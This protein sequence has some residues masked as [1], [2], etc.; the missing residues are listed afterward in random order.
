MQARVLKMGDIFLRITMKPYTY[1]LYHRPTKTHYYGVRTAKNCNPTELWESYFSTSKSV[2]RLIEE[3]GKDSFDCKVRKI[4]NDPLDALRWEHKFLSKIDAASR[5]DWLNKYNGG[6]T[7]TTAQQIPWNKGITHSESTKKILS[8][9]RK[10]Y[11][12]K[13]HPMFG[14]RH[15]EESKEKMSKN[16]KRRFGEK[17]HFYGKRHTDDV[18]KIISKKNTGR[19]S[20]N[21]G[22]PIS[23]ERKLRQSETMKNKP[24]ITC[25]F[26]KKIGHPSGM[27]RY[28]FDRCKFK[29]ST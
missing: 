19:P 8:E 16:Q 2:K 6:N 29:K 3:Y 28:H 10:R 26:C 5:L 18:K 13:R 4:F 23:D 25:P 17:N 1:Y 14:K 24:R 27:K 15:T 12:G 11:T 7:F 22:I 20:P 9:A 21:K